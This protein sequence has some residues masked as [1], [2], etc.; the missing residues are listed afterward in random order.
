MTAARRG[1]RAPARERHLRDAA[2]DFPADVPLPAGQM[3]G[4]TGGAWLACAGNGRR[5]RTVGRGV[6]A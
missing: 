1:R 4:A 5:R 3:Q 2:A 6:S